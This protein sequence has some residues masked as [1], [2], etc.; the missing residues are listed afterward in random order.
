M[1]ERTKRRYKRYWNN[2]KDVKL[3]ILL[4]FL[5]LM[6]LSAFFSTAATLLN[7]KGVLLNSRQTLMSGLGM[8]CVMFFIVDVALMRKDYYILTHKR[9]Y[10]MVSYISHCAFAFVNLLSCRFFSHTY[11]YAFVFSITKFARYTH[12][13]I[14]PMLSAV[15]FN[16]VLIIAIRYAPIGMKWLHL[17]HG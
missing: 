15:V 6:V 2:L 1:R 7:L 11:V 9:K 12:F 5:S 16:A 8:M 17:H 14:S 3:H 4:R 10:R 13:D